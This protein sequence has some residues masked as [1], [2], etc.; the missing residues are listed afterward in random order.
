M[1]QRFFEKTKLD[2]VVASQYQ[3]TRKTVAPMAD[4]RDLAVTVI[5]AGEPEKLIALIEENRGKTILVSGHSNTVPDLIGRLGCGTVSIDD[6][7]Y[8]FLFLAV[9]GGKDC[10]LQI[11]QLD[12]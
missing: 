12:P 11:W 6:A 8:S 1:L 3:R 2:M 10:D 4:D 9:L 5:P 7:Q